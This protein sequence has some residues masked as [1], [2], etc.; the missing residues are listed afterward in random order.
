MEQPKNNIEEEIN[1]SSEKIDVAQLALEYEKKNKLLPKIDGFNKIT[2]IN[3][4]LNLSKP[5]E[6]DFLYDYSKILGAS[7]NDPKIINWQLQNLDRLYSYGIDITVLQKR[8]K[9]QKSGSFNLNRVIDNMSYRLQKHGKLAPNNDICRELPKRD[10][11]SM[12]NIDEDEEMEDNE[13]IDIEEDLNIKSD[14][15]ISGGKNNGG[16]KEKNVMSINLIS[17]NENKKN[18]NNHN[19]YNGYEDN[20]YDK[21]DP[22]IDDELDKSSENNELLFKLT[23]APGNYTEAEILNNLKKNERKLAKKNN[24]KSK[25]KIKTLKKNHKLSKTK[26]KNSLDKSKKK[27]TKLIKKKRNLEENNENV[28]NGKENSTKKNSFTKENLENLTIDKIKLLFKQLTDN[29]DSDLITKH[30]QES[31][32]RR[33]I[34]N[35]LEIYDK[36]SNDFIL[37]LNEQFNI[38]DK[39]LTKTLMEYEIFKSGVENKYSNFAKFVNKFYSILNENGIPEIISLEQL[40]NFM[41]SV[42]EI[43]KSISHVAENIIQYR[44]RFNLY[45]GKHYFDLYKINEL[46]KDFVQ[47]IRERNLE[48]IT[49]LSAKF[50][51]YEEKYKLKF[52]KNILIQYMKEK[53]PKIDFG[54]DYESD[55][56]NRIFPLEVFVDYDMGA[57]IKSFIEPVEEIEINEKGKKKKK[58][59]KNGIENKNDGNNSNN[60]SIQINNEVIKIEEVETTNKK[61]GTFEN[62]INNFIKKNKNNNYINNINNNVNINKNISE[63]NYTMNLSYDNF[64]DDINSNNNVWNKPLL[65]NVPESSNQMIS[66]PSFYIDKSNKNNT[67]ISIINNTSLKNSNNFAEISSGMIISSSRFANNNISNININEPGYTNIESHKK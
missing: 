4:D 33:N 16:D 9:L 8:R 30:G 42:P 24:N 14:N 58:Y 11:N 61:S 65:I 52:P 60:N 23:L 7:K 45:M 22:F 66:N 13:E 41:V 36:N 48:Y 25:K 1:N 44:L 62:M 55:M 3:Y 29:Y 10:E 40:K 32:I 2:Y 37:V 49:K 34:K 54:G 67:G 59:K 19:G 53:N 64:N 15:S 35:I 39:D 5:H 47:N 21:N 38:N 28:V 56:N 20:F 50:I 46:L 26:G 51:E 31:F 17:N 63:K 6:I 43:E 27:S 12:I 57:K 18:C